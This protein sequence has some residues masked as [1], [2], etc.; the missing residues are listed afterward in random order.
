MTARIR[1]EIEKR[2]HRSGMQATERE[3]RI[4]GIG[5]PS[6]S[7]GL[8]PFNVHHAVHAQ[9]LDALWGRTKQYVT[10]GSEYPLILGADRLPD[11]PNPESALQALVD[12]VSPPELTG[13]G[14]T[15]GPMAAMFAKIET[16][17]YETWN[18]QCREILEPRN[19]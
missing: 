6:S 17:A 11:D 5:F 3:D 4:K 15:V 10:T 2:A 7:N 9:A 19:G 14:T 13:E 16:D 1:F 8:S 18:R 12:H